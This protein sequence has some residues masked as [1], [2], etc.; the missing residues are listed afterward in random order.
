[1]GKKEIEKYI[2]G[3]LKK[4]Y[5]FGKI[6]AALVDSGYSEKAAE[7]IILS[8]KSKGNILKWATVSC[9]SLLFVLSL[10][11]SGSGIVGMVTM[12]YD[13]PFEHEINSIVNESSSLSWYVPTKGELTSISIEGNLLG[14]GTAKVYIENNG[15]YLIFD[16]SQNSGTSV[17]SELITES[18]TNFKDSCLDT[19]SLFGFNRSLYKLRFELDD[20]AL[21]LK[22]IIYGIKYNSDLHEVPEFLPIGRLKT[23]VGNTL[24]IDLD[25]FFNT[26]YGNPEYGFIAEEG[27]VSIEINGNIARITPEDAGTAHFYFTSQVAGVLFMSNL[28]ELE[29]V[30]EDYTGSLVTGPVNKE[31]ILKMASKESNPMLTIV[32][33]SI[34][35]AIIITL[36]I[37]PSR[38]YDMNTLAKKIDSSRG[39]S[40]ISSSLHYYKKMK[41]TLK[42]KTIPENEKKKIITEMEKKIKKVSKDLPK[43]RQLKDFNDIERK[44]GSAIKNDKAEAKKLYAQLRKIY[45]KVIERNIGEAR[46]KELYKKMDKYYKKI[47]NS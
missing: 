39:T 45:V 47:Q 20:S 21:E 38:F 40:H 30:S 36:A 2:T 43:D 3:C 23:G 27:A 4:G 14:Q 5:S 29:I 7:G 28:V 22:K 35:V 37:I 6:E 17:S 11:L 41:T 46:K 12:G 32:L 9:L 15:D 24:L 1:M 13:V 10:F 18:I 34:I 19:C 16:S 25:T 42:D 26:S 31:T 44:L 8:Y 33:L